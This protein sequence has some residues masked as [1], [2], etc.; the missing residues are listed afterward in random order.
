MSLLKT[1]LIISIAI[2]TSCCMAD[3]AAPPKPVYHIYA[4]NTH[5][6]TSFTWSHGDQWVK[7]KPPAAG[8]KKEPALYVDKEGAQHPAKTMMLKPDWEK[9]QGPPAAHFELAKSNGYDFY[10][11][12]DHSQ[13][14]DFQPPDPANANWSATLKAAAD[15]TDAKF[16]ALAGYEHSEN[17]GPN[18]TGH[19]N[20]INSSTYLN[21]LANGVDLPTFYKWLKTVK[22]NGQGPIVASFNHPG[23]HQYNDWDYRD[24]EVTDIITMLEVINSNKNIHYEGFINALDKGWKVS[25]VCGNDNHG[26]WGITHQTSRTFVL[27]TEPTKLA[28]LDAMKHRR[29]YASLEGNLHC[30]YTVNGEIMGSTLAKPEVFQFEITVSDP[31]TTEAKDK[32]TKIDIVKDKG[33]IAQTYSPEPAHSVTWKPII[34]DSTAKYF[35]IRVWNAGGGDAPNADPAKPIAWLAPLWTGR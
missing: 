15:A 27:A 14:A 31:D 18:G 28:I 19:L 7:P 8:E 33:E 11:S 23:P 13:D 2:S 4:G 22:P 5:A 9:F 26:L 35:F 10:V 16:V 3:D 29:T 6:H 30:T 17:N 32:I 21:A 12:S 20:V 1:I 25:P 24:A 34:K